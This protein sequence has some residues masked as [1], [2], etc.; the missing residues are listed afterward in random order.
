[1]NSSNSIMRNRTFEMNNIN[2][3]E[4]C[5]SI[6]NENNSI[7]F[8]NEPPF[9]PS[10]NKVAVD[11][12]QFTNF[13]LPPLQQPLVNN[14]KQALRLERNRLAAKECRERRKDYIIRLETRV[15]KFEEENEILRKKIRETKIRIELFEKNL[16][17][18]K[19]LEQK[20]LELQ[21]ELCKIKT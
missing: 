15:G 2:D 20:V 21:D 18:R 1:M 3:G 9:N 19:E 13:V 7:T 17:E 4:E 5:D 10:T 8:Y 11:R 12:Q 16:L 6:V 14:Q